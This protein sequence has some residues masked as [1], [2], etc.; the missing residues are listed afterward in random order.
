MIWNFALHIL[1]HW[2]GIAVGVAL[3][4]VGVAKPGRLVVPD[5]VYSIAIAVGVAL[6][7]GGY[8]YDSGY[9][10]ALHGVEIARLREDLAQAN[11]NISLL[12]QTAVEANERE[13][14]AAEER[15]SDTASINRY[16]RELAAAGSD[17]QLTASELGRMREL[18]RYSQRQLAA[19]RA[20]SGVRP[21]SGPSAG[22]RALVA[23]Y[24]GALNEANRR[25]VNDGLFYSSVRQNYCRA[26]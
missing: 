25:L 6:A 17:L 18:V 7:G 15:H 4:V 14:A 19:A 24:I 12:Q 10:A 21:A 8:L 26:N 16:I 5:F 23:E 13:R 9:R 1:G 20:S 22:C 3:L 11:T 2:L